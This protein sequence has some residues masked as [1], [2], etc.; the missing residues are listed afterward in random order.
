MRAQATAVGHPIHP[1]LIVFPLGLFPVAVIF[2]LTY[3]Y[4]KNSEWAAVSYWVIA[5]GIIGALLAAVFGLIDWLK[6]P[7]GTRA[8]TIGLV[9]GITNVVV[10]GLFIVSWLL[11]RPN[12][13][14]PDLL[15]IGLGVVGLCLRFSP[16]G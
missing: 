6:I 3:W 4:T 10:A 9:H 11:R 12:P 16:V 14:A 1:M 7:D 8:K 5:A 13:S 15:D 2:D